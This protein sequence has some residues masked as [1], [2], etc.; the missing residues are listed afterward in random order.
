MVFVF[1]VHITLLC[2]ICLFVCF[3]TKTC[4]ESITG[5]IHNTD[6]ENVLNFYLLNRIYSYPAKLN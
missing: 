3:F 6:I 4:N 1:E 2:G 5:I